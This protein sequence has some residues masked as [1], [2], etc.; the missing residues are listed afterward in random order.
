M[1]R[2]FPYGISSDSAVQINPRRE[3]SRLSRL[4]SLPGEKDQAFLPV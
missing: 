1:I 3:I 4:Y 2:D